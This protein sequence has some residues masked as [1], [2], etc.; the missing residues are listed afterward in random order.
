MIRSFPSFRSCV[1]PAACVLLALPGLAIAAGPMPAVAPTSTAAGQSFDPFK[2]QSAAYEQELNKVRLSSVRRKLEQNRLEIA[3]FKAKMRALGG[4]SPSAGNAADNA[5]LKALTAKVAA[6]ESQIK[7]LRQPHT[8]SAKGHP[9]QGSSQAAVKPDRPVLVG[10][11]STTKG[12]AAWFRQGQRVVLAHDGGKVG[13]WTVNYVGTR[14]AVLAAPGRTGHV[15]FPLHGWAGQA[16]V[17]DVAGSSGVSGS[18]D[19]AAPGSTPAS[20]SNLYTSGTN[21]V[22]QALKAGH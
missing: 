18:S 13:T 11:V 20:S 5:A 17:S 12:R 21:S 16:V 7:T 6:L 8:V 15:V 4:A 22:I 19:G 9:A 1:V 3:R 2:G 10:I 14:G